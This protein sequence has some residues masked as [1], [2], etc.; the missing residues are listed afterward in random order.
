MQPKDFL[1]YLAPLIVV[2]VIGLRFF[3]AQKPRKIKPGR[4]WIGPIYVLVGMAAVFANPLFPSPFAN[5]YS[6]PLF[7]AAALV[8]CGAGYLRALHQE[9]SIDP[10]TGDVMS[11]ASPVALMVFVAIFLVRFGMNTWMGGGANAAMGKLP[12]PGLLL[13]T[14]A[15]LFFAFG[16][17]SA[18]AWEVWR[19]TRPLVL[20]HRAARPPAPPA[21]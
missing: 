15:M 20:E 19:R 8:G 9:F 11:K 1:P 10:E 21:V 12:S 13:Y 4:L 2:L 18:S 5:P 7:A 3:R 6:I 14:D 16:M 17:V